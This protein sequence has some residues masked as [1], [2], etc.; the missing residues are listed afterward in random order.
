MLV[1]NLFLG[2]LFCS[3]DTLRPE[4]LSSD[5]TFL[6][7]LYYERPNFNCQACKH[8]RASLGSL[9]MPVKTI[10]FADDVRLGSRFMQFTFPAFIVRSNGLSRIL[11]PLNADE[12]KYIIEEEKWKEVKLINPY[13]EVDSK[14]VRC[15][16]MVNPLIFWVINKLYYIVDNV[17]EKLVYFVVIS[18]ITYLIYSIIEIFMEP[19]LKAKIE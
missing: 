18:I 1:L 13:L 6:V 3:V 4:D 19:D 2:F 9:K 16:S 12:L 11:N 15:F 7:F 10:N 8:F 5:S 14:I 17:P